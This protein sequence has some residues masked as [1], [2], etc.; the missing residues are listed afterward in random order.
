MSIH[1]NKAELT[2]SMPPLDSLGPYTACGECGA[3]D[4]WTY[5]RAWARCQ[6]GFVRAYH[7]QAAPT[8][9]QIAAACELVLAHAMATGRARY[10]G[11]VEMKTKRA[12]ARRSFNR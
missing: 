6:C 5:H 9:E 3:T 7:C 4:A 2:A 1:R 10:G 8:P 11:D 12:A